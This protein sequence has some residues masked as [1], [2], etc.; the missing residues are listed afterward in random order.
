MTSGSENEAMKPVLQCI[1]CQRGTTKSLSVAA[2]ANELRRVC[3]ECKS[4]DNCLQRRSTCKGKL[5]AG[6]VIL[7]DE[8]TRLKKEA[9]YR[10]GCVLR[11]LVYEYRHTCTFQRLLPYRQ[12]WGGFEK[13]ERDSLSTSHQKVQHPPF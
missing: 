12:P 13:F 4:Y 10:S 9:L 5:V 8:Q 7:T 1:K 6:E 11:V 3:L 2:G